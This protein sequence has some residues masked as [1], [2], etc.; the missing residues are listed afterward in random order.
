MAKKQEQNVQNEL[1]ELKSALVA[2]EERYKADMHAKLHHADEQAR[3]QIAQNP[4]KSVGIA[5]GAGA[6]IGGMIAHLARK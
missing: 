2:L 4:Y 1:Q 3:E 6:L 5:F